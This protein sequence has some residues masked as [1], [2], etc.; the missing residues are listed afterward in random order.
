MTKR[1]WAPCYERGVELAAAGCPLD[2]LD[3]LRGD[4]AA[5]GKS[6]WAKQL[7]G[8]AESCVYLLGESL[9]GFV[10]GLHLGTHRGAGTVIK[11]WNFV[12]PWPE[13]RI[14]WDY[15][16]TDVIPKHALGNYRSV[17][18]SRVPG[19][20]NE[21]RMLRRGYP[22]EGLLC[23]YSNQPVPY[24]G[25]GLISGKLRLIDE[26]GKVVSLSLDLRIVRAA[27][28]RSGKNLRRRRDALLDKAD[29]IP[30]GSKRV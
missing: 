28:I 17:L 6:F 16:A 22:V 20:L 24:P 26:N 21:R 18:D 27:A 1:I 11:H 15:A 2:Y 25:E 4:P 13:H 8:Y 30:V 12:P 5:G 10:I 23:G 19:I 29:Q 9:T 7:R 3:A 14:C